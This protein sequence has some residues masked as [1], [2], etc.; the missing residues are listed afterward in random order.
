MTAHASKKHLKQFGGI[1]DTLLIGSIYLVLILILLIILLP[2][3][4]IVASSFSSASA[5]TA[6]KVSFWPVDFSLEGYEAVFNN[7][8]MLVLVTITRATCPALPKTSCMS[9]LI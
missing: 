6:G 4:N 3:I 2:L 7:H 1:G 9:L 5:V 8:L